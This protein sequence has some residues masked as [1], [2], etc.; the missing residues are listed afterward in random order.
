MSEIKNVLN[1]QEIDSFMKVETIENSGITWYSPKKHP[2][3]LSGFA[4]FD[5][6]GIYRRLPLKPKWPVSQQV[7]SLANNTSGGQISLK[8]NSSRLLIKASLTAASNMYH[9]PATGQCGF[10]CYLGSPLNQIYCSTTKYDHTQTSYEY[11]L[12]DLKEVKMREITL[13]FPLYQ[14]VKEILLGLIKDAEVYPPEPYVINKPVVFYGTSIT[15]GG[16]ASRPGMSFTNIISRRL[17]I[18]CINL[19]FS[20]NGRGEPE[21]ARIFT[22]I[23]NPACIVLDYEANASDG[24]LERTLKEFIDILRDKHPF[25]P[26]LVLSKIRYATE[27]YNQNALNKRLQLKQFQ[28]DLINDLRAKGDENIY[29]YAGDLFLGDDFDECTVDGVHPTDLGFMRIAQKLAPLLES[30]LFPY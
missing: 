15:Q 11:V 29:F 19:G 3:R 4:W 30:I 2:F 10:D 25:V 18:E 9:M 5:M 21:M 22:K 6:D 17:N 26:V 12:F 27:N 14:G 20:G 8:T 24:T 1:I 16:C 7:D 13:N 23:K 28:Y